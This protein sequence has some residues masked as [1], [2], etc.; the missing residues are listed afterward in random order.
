MIQKIV[1]AHNAIN[2]K[3]VDLKKF[4]I[5]VIELPIEQIKKYEEMYNNEQQHIQLL[6]NTY[7]TLREP[8]KNVINERISK[9]DVHMTTDDIFDFMLHED[10]ETY[11][12]PQK[13]TQLE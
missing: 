9:R 13:R 3:Q 5:P 11:I 1:N 7:Q 4:I 12:P 6:Q 10:M 2:Q 8:I